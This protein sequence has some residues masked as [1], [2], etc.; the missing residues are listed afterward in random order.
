MSPELDRRERIEAWG[1][2]SSSLA[3]VYRPST[4][5]QILEAITE[6]KSN[7]RTVCFKGGGNSYGDA[8]QNS[9]QSVIDLSRMNRIL[10][11]SPDTGIIRCEPGVTIRQLWRYTIGDGWWP[12]VVSGTSFV[13]LGGALSANIHG[14]NNFREGPIGDHVNSFQLL[15]ENGTI[16]TCSRDENSDL[17]FAAI[18]GFGWLGCITEITMQMHRI[19]SGLINVEAISVRDLNHAL[20]LFSNRVSSCNYL[21][22][23]LDAFSNGRGL[24]HAANY[25]VAG[26][27]PHPEESLKLSA[28]ELPDTIGGWIAR[29]KLNKLMKPWVNSFGMKIINT[30]KYRSGRK[31][32]GHKFSQ[33]LSA[34]NFLLDS[35]PNW[36]S[37]YKPGFLVQYQ[38]FIPEQFAPKSFEQILILCKERGI[39]PFLAVLKRHRP[40]DFL[41][42]HAVDGYSLAL[43]FRVTKK[44]HNRFKDLVSALDDIVFNAGGKFYFAKD[45][46]LKAGSANIFLGEERTSSFLQLKSK[47]DPDGLF[48]S[49]LFR[50]VF[51]H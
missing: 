44:N 28:Q 42:S 36:K 11:W 9:E 27:D 19:H 23:W 50:R 38:P 17:F 24:L 16:L 41:L 37:S 32:H 51:K 15:L 39:P 25:L 18:G 40:D 13:T 20:E 30:M 49:D 7:S 45:S 43:D 22:G 4:V 8:F 21:V 1:M 35:A 48:L 3:F 46:T 29:S 10:E 2:S 14:K 26:E 47:Y 31:Q 34:F 33:S 6:S 12:P 5:E